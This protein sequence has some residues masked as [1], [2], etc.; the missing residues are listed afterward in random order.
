MT[1]AYQERVMVE[2]AEL[3]DKVQKLIRFI[4]GAGYQN[5]EF[6]EQVLLVEQLAFMEAYRRV[7]DARIER[8]PLLT[9]GL[10]D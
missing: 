10:A 5:L 7:L 1:E 4:A 6:A 2:R 3:D 9:S 8:W